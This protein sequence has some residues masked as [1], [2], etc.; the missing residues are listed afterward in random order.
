MV[1]SLKG[2]MWLPLESN[3]AVFTSFA[4]KLGYPTIMYGFHDVYG[5]DPDAW[6]CLPQPC[7]AVVLLYQIKKQHKDLIKG[8]I[9]AQ[10]TKEG[11]VSDEKL[12]KPFFIKQTIGNACGTIAMLH[13]VCNTVDKVGGVRQDSFLENFLHIPQTP[14]DRAKYL[15]QD[16][17]LE[18]TH[19]VMANEGTTDPHDNKDT[20][21]HFVCYIEK[22]GKLW[23]LD[24]RLDQ[25]VCKAQLREGDHL[26]MEASKII[27]N[28]IQMSD[29]VKFNVMALAPAADDFY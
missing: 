14:L 13:A 4:E 16:E 9:E 2:K 26:G 25:P 18:A 21:C 23:E 5:L 11:A 28:Y 10:L 17:K 1:E 22:D 6:M 8:E 15:E 19:E 24:G 29:D 12:E 27:Q 20:Q 7:I 3:P